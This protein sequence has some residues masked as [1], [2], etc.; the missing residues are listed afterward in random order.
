MQITNIRYLAKEDICVIELSGKINFDTL[1]SLFSLAVKRGQLKSSYRKFLILD[2]GI[3]E[4]NDH[5]TVGSIE[6]LHI[7]HDSEFAGAKVAFVLHDLRSHARV[8]TLRKKFTNTLKQTF[9]SEE[10]A[11]LWLKNL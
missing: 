9:T 7:E 6:K 5:S 3:E 1:S 11:M 4:T 2:D 10:D 8:Q